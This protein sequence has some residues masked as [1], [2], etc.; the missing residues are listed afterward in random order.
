MIHSFTGENR[1]LSNFFRWEF[2]FDGARY[3]TAEHAFQAEKPADPAW[4]ERIRAAKE[5]G[6]AK[7]L[8]REAP[9]HCTRAE[10]DAKRVDVMRRVLRAKFSDRILA[11]RLLETGDERLVEGNYWHDRWWGTVDGRGENMLGKLLMEVR[12]EIGDA[13]GRR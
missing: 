11:A 4:K 5:P 10:W 3:W 2:E 1:F 6:D 8:G 13:Q 7:R 9:L 12:K